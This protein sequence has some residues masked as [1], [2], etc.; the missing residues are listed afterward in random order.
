MEKDLRG[1]VRA[2]AFIFIVVLLLA[3]STE[4]FSSTESSGDSSSA[5]DPFS[6]L[7]IFVDCRQNE[8]ISTRM[9]SIRDKR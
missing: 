5:I 3:I 2:N 6:R 7:P 9:V 4:S 1:K 8:R